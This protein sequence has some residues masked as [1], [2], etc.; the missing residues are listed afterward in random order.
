VVKVTNALRPLVLITLTCLVAVPLCADSQVRIVRLSQVDG[1]V[2]IDRNAGQGYEKAFLNLPITEGMKIRTGLDGR[3]EVEFEDGSALR[4]TPDTELEFPELSMRD[5]G[6]RVS[7]VVL[8]KG[9]AYLNFKRGKDDEFTLNFGREKVALEKPAHLRVE[10]GDLDAQLAVFSGDLH[11]ESPTGTFTLDKRQTAT[12]ELAGEGRYT[13]AKNLEPGLYDDWDKQE[14]KYHAQYTVAS[15]YSPYGYG[16]SDL[17]YY[18]NYF[19][20]PGYGLCWQPYF[21]GLGWDPF[22][23]GS[24]LWY[25][26]VGYTWISAYPWGWTP[27][28][29]GT[30]F[31]MAGRGWVWSPG[32][33][34]AGWN[35]VPRVIDPPRGFVSPRPPATPGQTVLVNRGPMPTAVGTGTKLLIRND[36]AALGVPRGSVR[37]LAKASAQVFERGTVTERAH[38]TVMTARPS[39]AAGFA[40]SGAGSGRSASSRLS[41]GPRS[42]A[43]PHS[44]S[45][46]SAPASHASS[47]PHR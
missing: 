32:N 39:T 30:W 29:Y 35:T 21:V 12:F 9:T 14:D 31:F 19:N 7:T 26:G 5:S 20:A 22:M 11:V 40:M 42:A 25:P 37:N 38:P 34:W 45:A 23:N 33:S 28:R 13:I 15:N 10:V 46:H 6:G 16:V 18:G 2:Q 8:R 36:S 4:V 41:A 3:V 17:G 1:N 24:W 43:T 47:V 27:Y 44:G